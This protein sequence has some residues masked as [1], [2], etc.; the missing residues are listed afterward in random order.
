MGD[1]AVKF[2]SENIDLPVYRNLS[3]IDGKE[4]ASL[5]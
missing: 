4:V 1:G 5:E 2:V 3:T